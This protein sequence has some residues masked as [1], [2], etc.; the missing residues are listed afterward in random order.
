[1]L[2]VQFLSYHIVLDL[3]SE[4]ETMYDIL[5]NILVLMERNSYALKAPIYEYPTLSLSV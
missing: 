1:M 4:K 3:L 2:S 5:L